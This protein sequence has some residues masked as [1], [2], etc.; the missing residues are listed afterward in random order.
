[1]KDILAR[2]TGLDG[3]VSTDKA[4]APN[5]KEAGLDGNVIRATKLGDLAAKPAKK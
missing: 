2:Q 4:T 5:I 3:I 1:M